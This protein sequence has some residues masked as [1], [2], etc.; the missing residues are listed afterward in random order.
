MNE[1][2]QKQIANYILGLN[3]ITSAYIYV[4]ACKEHFFYNSGECKPQ[5]DNYRGFRQ[6][7]DIVI[8]RLPKSDREILLD[9][10]NNSIQAFIFKSGLNVSAPVFVVTRKL[11]ADFNIPANGVC[12]RDGMCFIFEELIVK[13]G[14]GDGVQP[15]IA[16]EI[17]HSL[18]MAKFLSKELVLPPIDNPSPEILKYLSKMGYP[19]HLWHEE[20][21]VDQLLSKWGYNNDL[22]TAWEFAA[23]SL[24]N[25]PRKIYQIT[26]SRLN[27]LK[28][29][30]R[31]T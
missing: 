8:N 11:S 9:Y 14:P 30:T 19:R 7:L 24:C 21:L 3:P 29:I 18:L 25:D 1:T 16:H 15:I 20:I 10:W 17:A 12:S 6:N 5:V 4:Y 28:K 27:R 31:Q 23:R 2:T 22:L 26:K 13:N